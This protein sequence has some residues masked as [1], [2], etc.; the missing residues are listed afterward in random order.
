MIPCSI[1]MERDF[2]KIKIDHGKPNSQCIFFALPDSLGYAPYDRRVHLNYL[3]IYRLSPFLEG[4]ANFEPHGMNQRSSRYRSSIV[5]Q[6]G[7][8][9]IADA[10]IGL[11]RPVPGIAFARPIGE[12]V[13]AQAA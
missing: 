4:R 1:L 8:Y 6:R 11:Q 5:V 3:G 10:V 9:E 7:S 12:L 13:Q 2:Q